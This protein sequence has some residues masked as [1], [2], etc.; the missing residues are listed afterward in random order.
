VVVVVMVVVT[1]IVAMGMT[2]DFAA[3]G[4][5][6]AVHHQQLIHHKLEH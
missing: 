5:V 3:V 2:A 4:P 6:A 1:D